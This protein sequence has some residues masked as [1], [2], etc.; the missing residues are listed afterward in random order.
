MPQAFPAP[1]VLERE[2]ELKTLDVLIPTDARLSLR[3]PFHRRHPTTTEN[4]FR[5]AL[6][7]IFIA[8]MIIRKVYEGRAAATAMESLKTDRDKPLLIAFQS[9]L[10]MVS[11]VA[12]V[13][14]VV[15]PS[16]MVWSSLWIP[17]WS[18]WSGVVLGAL[19]TV[20]LLW[21]HLTLGRNFFGG[22]KIRQDHELVTRGPFRW[23]RHPMYVA[24]TTLGIAFTLVS[25]NW[26]VGAAWLAGTA[27]TLASRA[28]VEDAM[29]EEEFGDEY[30]KYRLITGAFFPKL[31]S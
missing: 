30:R 31:K 23:V 25:A 15:K 26:L 12:M 9:M 17:V 11:L 22:V 16:I 24:F 19:G 4:T 21:T 27:V 29:L 28:G 6:A 3:V 2:G 8:V 18:R 13:L 10:M 14:C 7:A 20:L 5:F 1:G